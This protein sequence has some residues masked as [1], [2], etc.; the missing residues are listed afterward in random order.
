MTSQKHTNISILAIK[1]SNGRMRKIDKDKVLEI[2]E[3]ISQLGTLLQ[4]IVI[5][6][7]NKLIS[8]LHRLEAYKLLKKDKIPVRIIDFPK[9]KSTLAEIDENLKRNELNKIEIGEHLIKR[10]ELLEKMGIRTKVGDNQYSGNGSEESFTTSQQLS[11][12][13][14]IH[15]RTYYHLKQISKNITPE[16]KEL[17]KET[18]VSDNLDGLISISR[19][20]PDIQVRV[21]EILSERDVNVSNAITQAENEKIITQPPSVED[22]IDPVSYTHLT[23]PTIYS[24]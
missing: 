16:T 2:S 10:D 13:I 14:G 11:D 15:K 24:V 12:E 20:K 4:P 18:R 1:K 21:G 9:L 22:S 3:S 23:L 8:G 17:L 6:K 5:D 19:T 7:N